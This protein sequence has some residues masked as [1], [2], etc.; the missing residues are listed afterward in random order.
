MDIVPV[1][2]IPESGISDAN[3]VLVKRGDKLKFL[4]GIPAVEVIAIVDYRNGLYTANTP[5]NDPLSCTLENLRP[6]VGD[7]TIHVEVE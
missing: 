1:E 7:F 6:L 3:G 5:N 2:N 4:Y